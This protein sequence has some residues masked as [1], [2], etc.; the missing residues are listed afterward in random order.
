M[1]RGHAQHPMLHIA[2][3]ETGCIR[4]RISDITTLHAMNMQ[5]WRV[6]QALRVDVQERVQH[7]Q[8]NQ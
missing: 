2:S 1:R 4:I 8:Q 5:T 7:L 6:R 3:L